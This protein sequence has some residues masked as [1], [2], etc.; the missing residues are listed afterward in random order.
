M[1]NLLQRSSA[2]F[3]VLAL[4][5]LQSQLVAQTDK[6]IPK[7]QYSCGI[8]GKYLE[9]IKKKNAAMPNKSFTPAIMEMSN[10]NSRSL[11]APCDYTGSTK[12]IKVYYHHM[13][14]N[15]GTGNF[16]ET[17]DGYVGRP[18]H[19][20]GINGYNRAE[21][22]IEFANKKMDENYKMFLPN[23][24]S[25]PIE[26]K[27]VQFILAGVRFHRNDTWYNEHFDDDQFQLNQV[28]GEEL[29]HAI[30]IYSAIDPRV[31][32]TGIA[33]DI[34]DLG[35]VYDYLSVKIKDWHN[36]AYDPN[37]EGAGHNLVHEFCHCL[38]L[39]HDFF[40]DDC[41]DTPIHPNCWD[42]APPACDWSNV[43]NN[44]M[45]SIGGWHECLSPCQIKRIQ[46]RLTTNLAPYVETC[47]YQCNPVTPKINL[48]YGTEY[49]NWDVNEM[50]WV[51]APYV[52]NQNATRSKFVIKKDGSIIH[53]GAWN[54]GNPYNGSGYLLSQITST[55]FH[56]S[57]VYGINFYTDN[58]PSCP[59][60]RYDF[61]TFTVRDYYDPTCRFPFEVSPN[62]SN[63]EINVEYEGKKGDLFEVYLADMTGNKIKDLEKKNTKLEGGRKQI[64]SSISELNNGQY[65]VI[66]KRNGI[67]FKKS[68]H[69]SK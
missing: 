51:D 8:H 38:G 29:G 57:G 3:S 55:S 21:K 39:F 58:Y 2:F 35:S 34:S 25:T 30:N 9:N 45:S 23:P 26:P 18:F 36:S 61:K 67:V 5:L 44:T 59:E 66:L 10:A 41:D 16:N 20:P 24:N 32:Y 48:T 62:P 49:C 37:D 28:F 63:G 12:F 40:P 22:V 69:L 17:N 42:Y 46:D 50:L 14:K 27:R 60:V 56:L 43:S 1:K 65:F 7:V 68:L 6:A 4:L 15:D 33:S 19:R 64:Q 31:P 54:S 13:L 47:S 11:L 53:D 52:E